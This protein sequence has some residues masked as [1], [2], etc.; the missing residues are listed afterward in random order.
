MKREPQ[1]VPDRERGLLVMHV[2]A[3][4]VSTQPF[5]MEMDSCAAACLENQ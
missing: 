2:E 3:A 4:E 1:V 5:S